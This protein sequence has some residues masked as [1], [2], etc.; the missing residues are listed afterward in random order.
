MLVYIIEFWDCHYE[1]IDSYLT[2]L[3][4]CKDQCEIKVF[5]LNVKLCKEQMML[6]EKYRNI[7]VNIHPIQNIEKGRR[8]I[9]VS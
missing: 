4:R 5:A 6:K 1:L 2:T 8:L 3:A 7:N 9:Y